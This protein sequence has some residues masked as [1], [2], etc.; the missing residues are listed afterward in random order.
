MPLQNR[1][2]KREVE[3]GRFRQ[4]LY[5]RLNVVPIEVAP[6][7]RREQD[8]AVLAAHFLELAAKRFNRP[9]RRLTQANLLELQRY[10]WQVTCASY[11]M[12]SKGRSSR[13]VAMPCA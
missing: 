5:Y 12:L 8:I 1:D 6:L 2:L 3:A 9:A 11:K 13:Q 4:D 7:R 10:E